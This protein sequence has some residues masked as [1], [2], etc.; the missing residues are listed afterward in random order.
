M[1]ELRYG[2]RTRQE[3]LSLEYGRLSFQNA[4]RK[5]TKQSHQ[6]WKFASQAIILLVVGSITFQYQIGIPLLIWGFRQLW[7]LFKHKGIDIRIDFYWRYAEGSA[8]ILSS[9]NIF[10]LYEVDE[11]I[12]A[13]IPT[14]QSYPRGIIRKKIGK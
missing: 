6:N 10:H 12:A 5:I 1:Q 13:L 4:I 8:F 9:E 2:L 3:S 7:F 11:E 14:L